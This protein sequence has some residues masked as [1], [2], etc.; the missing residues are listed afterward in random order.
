ML[1]SSWNVA[2]QE[3]V[4][5]PDIIPLGVVFDSIADRILPTTSWLLWQADAAAQGRVEA[6]LTALENYLRQQTRLGSKGMPFDKL[7]NDSREPNESMMF[8]PAAGIRRSA[9]RHEQEPE[10]IQTP[11]P[12][13]T[14]T[15]ADRAEFARS[16]GVSGHVLDAMLKKLSP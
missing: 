12:E 16:F 13:K 10:K 9:Q 4:R 14:L 2:V 7:E 11:A 1:R 5:A 8:G 6:R 15:S 3:S